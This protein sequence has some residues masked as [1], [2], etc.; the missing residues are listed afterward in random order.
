MNIPLET[1][2]DT[3][4]CILRIPKPEDNNCV[5]TASRQ[6][7][8]TDGMTWD[9]PKTQEEI[10]E[11]RQKLLE[12]WKSGIDY[13]FSICLKE[14]GECIGR[15]AMR[16]TEKDAVWNVG[17]WLHPDFQGKG[18]MTE[19]LACITDWTFDVLK[20]SSI[21]AEHATWNTASG[22]LLKR[23][24]FTHTGHNPEVPEEEYV[25]KKP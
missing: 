18:Y 12:R 11:N 15:I 2:L 13:G 17:F 5:W 19:A 23:C 9:P 16:K 8:F 25:L 20:A 14:S 22:A 7:G 21:E 10:E 4:R 6:P 24:G 3:E 1:I